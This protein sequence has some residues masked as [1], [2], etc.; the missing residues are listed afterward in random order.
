METKTAGSNLFAQRNLNHTN[1]KV[2]A[3]GIR[4]GANWSCLFGCEGACLFSG[5]NPLS[6]AVVEVACEC[7]HLVRKYME[8]CGDSAEEE[9]SL[10]LTDHDCVERKVVIEDLDISS[11]F[12]VCVASVKNPLCQSMLYLTVIARQDSKRI[13]FE[14]PLSQVMAVQT[15]NSASSKKINVH[16][17]RDELVC[18]HLSSG[19]MYVAH[20][21][22]KTYPPPE[23]LNGKSFA[24]RKP[25][26][27][28]MR[29]FG[30]CFHGAPVSQ[31]SCSKN[32]CLALL[33][34]GRCLSFGDNRYGQRGSGQTSVDDLSHASELSAFIL[35]PVVEHVIEGL[36][37]MKMIQVSCGAF[38]CA[39]LSESGDVFT[40]GWNKWGQL[41]NTSTTSTL[42]PELIATEHL[43]RSAGGETE[44]MNFSNV[45]C[46]TRHTIVISS[47]GEVYGCGSNE[48]GQLN[49]NELNLEA[50]KN[51]F[52][53]EQEVLK[54]HLSL[55]HLFSATGTNWL[56]SCSGWNTLISYL[57]S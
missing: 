29:V 19:K 55:K 7:S 45:Q 31:I 37:G 21:C 6:D 52:A 26:E 27:F 50:A 10:F 32:H 49:L 14:I 18:I 16:I 1:G 12:V 5:Y 51:V 11:S 38:H 22:T 56:L 25:S 53:Y 8:E 43:E 13:D 28:L 30:P 46:G 2:R 47:K 4:S 33:S 48:F 3:R 44:L 24:S 9:K 41:G 23:E 34:D 20:M 35:S 57:P 15:V 42:S 36:G 40:W 17:Y 39:A 54:C